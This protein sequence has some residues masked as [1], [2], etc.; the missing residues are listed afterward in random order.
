[1]NNTGYV[2]RHW[3]YDVIE[4]KWHDVRGMNISVKFDFFG[5][6]GEYNF[7]FTVDFFDID[8]PDFY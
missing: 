5:G 2:E 4:A 8:S 6:K 1:M 7:I 3:G